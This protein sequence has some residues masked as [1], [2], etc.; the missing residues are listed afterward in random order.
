VAK[1]INAVLAKLSAIAKHSINIQ[2]ITDHLSALQLLLHDLNPVVERPEECWVNKDAYDA[3]FRLLRQ[4]S[5]LPDKQDSDVKLLI[6]AVGVYLH[7]LP[8]YEVFIAQ[9]KVEALAANYRIYKF[10]V[11]AEQL[12]LL[13][14]VID[15]HAT[16]FMHEL[17]KSNASKQ[18]IVHFLGQIRF[19]PRPMIKHYFMLSGAE[20]TSVYSL[21]LHAN[22]QGKYVGILADLLAAFP[23]QFEIFQELEQGYAPYNNV[24]NDSNYLV[25]L[26]HNMYSFVS[27]EHA[28]WVPYLEQEYYRDPV[29]MKAFLEQKVSQMTQENYTFL[30]ALCSANALDGYVSA[31]Y[32]SFS[33]CMK[34]IWSNHINTYTQVLKDHKLGLAYVYNAYNLVKLCEEA[35]ATLQKNIYPILYP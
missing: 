31:G 29:K 23:S 12:F 6:A 1:K 16:T 9:N 8:S 20:N 13:N 10:L 4:M 34:N 30:N 28:G 5:G 14:P 2:D 32:I 35:G 19:L 26:Q 17:F 7:A 27:H 15:G 21:I 25:K 24:F 22:Q 3:I 11:P 33:T 18:D